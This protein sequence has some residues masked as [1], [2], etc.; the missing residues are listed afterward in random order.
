MKKV[1]DAIKEL[2]RYLLNEDKCEISEDTIQLALDALKDFKPEP[3]DV[4][5][6]MIAFFKTNKAPYLSSGIVDKIDS[7]NNVYIKELDVTVQPVRVVPYHKGILLQEELTKAYN[8]YMEA[9]TLAESYL[10]KVVETIS[11]GSYRV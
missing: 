1:E 2:N 9:T 8:S 11:N 10:T 5:N 3:I 4:N 6:K 7:D